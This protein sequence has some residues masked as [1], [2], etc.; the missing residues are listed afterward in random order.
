MKT[1]KHMTLLLAQKQDGVHAQALV[2]QCGYSPGT[3]RSY[4]SHLRRQGLLERIGIRYGLTDKGR[5]RLHYF[6]IAGCAQPACPSCQGKD[7]HFTCPGCHFKL[8]R[9]EARIL[10]EWDFL[11]GVRHAGVYCPS[12]WK[13]M[14]PEDQA[15]L[16]GISKE[17]DR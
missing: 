14:F 9:S 15:V 7:G 11:I 3:A 2:R 4:L 10:A 12:C 17:R 5:T 8:R 13:L 6:E 1:N 16:L